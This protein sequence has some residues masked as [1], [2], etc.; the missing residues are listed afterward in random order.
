MLMMNIHRPSLLDPYLQ[1]EGAHARRNRCVFGEQPRQDQ[2][3][4]CH[5]CGQAWHAAS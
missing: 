4:Q 3:D 2:V 5:R 1:R